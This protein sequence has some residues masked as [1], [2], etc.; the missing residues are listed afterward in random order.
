MVAGHHFAIVRRDYDTSNSSKDR[1][2]VWDQI[3]YHATTVY[4]PDRP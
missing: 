3:P 4:I 2:K 1:A